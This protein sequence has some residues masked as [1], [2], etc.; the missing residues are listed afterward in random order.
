MKKGPLPVEFEDGSMAV[1]IR[2]QIPVPRGN[3]ESWDEASCE[4]AFQA[5]AKTCSTDDYPELAVFFGWIGL[6]YEEFTDW[7]S[8]QGYAKPTFWQPKLKEPTHKKCWKPKAGDKNKL[9]D[10]EEAVVRAITAIWPD[11]KLD[12]K[13]QHRDKL[14]NV[15]L[16]KTLNRSTVPSRVIQRALAKIQ[17]A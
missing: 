13:A 1:D 15:H 8:K 5:L 2:Q 12:H 7:L 17:F 10:H 9:T 16:N 14:I 4:D 6:S 11:G 3:P